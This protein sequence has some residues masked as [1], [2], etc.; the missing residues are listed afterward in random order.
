MISAHCIKKKMTRRW[1]LWLLI[2]E[3]IVGLIITFQI[4]RTP[5]TCIGF[6]CSVIEFD[7]LKVLLSNS[8]SASSKKNILR[9]ITKH[10]M[11]E[12]I[13]VMLSTDQLL[14]CIQLSPPGPR[15]TPEK[16]RGGREE[17]PR[18]L[19]WYLLLQILAVV[20]NGREGS[21]GYHV[22]IYADANTVNI[23]SDFRQQ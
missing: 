15:Q 10:Q 4:Y 9:S 3:N 11:C 6:T 14:Y 12:V 1:N 2:H 19:Y 20:H 16:G 21:T 17:G 5:S 13:D 7:A 8:I 18:S 23:L 22:V